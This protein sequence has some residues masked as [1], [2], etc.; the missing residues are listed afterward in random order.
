MIR[1]QHSPF[2]AQRAKRFGVY[3]VCVCVCVCGLD[4]TEGEIKGVREV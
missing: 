2:L 1:Q 3:G 4:E